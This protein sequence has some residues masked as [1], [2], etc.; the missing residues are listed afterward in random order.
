MWN[1]VLVVIPAVIMTLA[2]SALAAYALAVLEFRG[3]QF[4]YYLIVAGLTFPIF[5]AL[6]PLF[7]VVKD[8]SLLNTHHGLAIVYTAF[9][10]S[11]TVLFL[12]SFFR[13][14]PSEMREAA[15][16]DGANERQI[17]MYVILPLV[18][19]GLATMAIFNFL[20][21]W[22]QYILP[23]VLITDEDRYVLPQGLRF[24]TAQQQFDA[25]FSALFAAMTLIMVPTLAVYLVFQRRIEAGLTAGA[26]RG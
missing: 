7:F 3:R 21:Q 15:L 12:T 25:D 20:G 17:F 8:L 13:Q 14:V 24:L 23:L 26:L 1:S 2:V 5:L 22:N 16:V 6:V 4:F 19:P 9:S 10:L 11:F 18:K